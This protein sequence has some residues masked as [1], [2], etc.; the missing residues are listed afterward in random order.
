MSDD[1]LLD[2]FKRAVRSEDPRR[3]YRG[4]WSY[5]VILGVPGVGP[6]PAIVEARPEDD[7]LPELT[8]LECYPTAVRTGAVPANTVPVPGRTIYVAFADGDPSKPFVIQHPF[9]IIPVVAP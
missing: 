6:L 7:S 1:R 2:A 3:D 8:A 4:I 5:T 9:T